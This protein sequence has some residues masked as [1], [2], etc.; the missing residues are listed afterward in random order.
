MKLTPF[1]DKLFDK[2]KNA[3]FEDFEIFYAGG[4]SFRVRIF[5]G[6]VDEYSVNK[7]YGISFRG[8]SGG[9]MGYSYTEAFDD[10]AID[11]LIRHAQKNAEIIENEDK[12]FIFAGSGSYSEVNA[13]N[14]A[15]DAVSAKEKIAT[16]LRLEQLAKNSHPAI[17]S[18]A[19]TVIQSGSGRIKIKNSKGMDLS[20]EDN[21]LLCYTVPI[22]QKG[23]KKMDGTEFQMVRDFTELDP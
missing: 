1:I 3:D 8:L 21:F 2:A 16:A 19:T 20:F 22:A 13:Y 18:V 4:R 15:L 9:K 7:T 10:E 17:T 5:E 23:E 11:M 14:E 6:N 12:Q